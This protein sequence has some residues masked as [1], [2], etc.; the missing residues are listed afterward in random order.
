MLSRITQRSSNR[1]TKWARLFLV[2]AALLLCI[3]GVAKVVSALGTAPVLA[4]PDPIFGIR[5]DHLFMVVGVIELVIAVFCLIPASH[6]LA[7]GL[8]A[9]LSIDFL[10]YRAG[11]WLTRF[12][13]YCPCLGTLTQAIHLSPHRANLLTRIVLIYLMIGS[14][15]FL[16][17]FWRR[18]N[19]KPKFDPEFAC[20]QAPSG[21]L[22]FNG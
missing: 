13:G 10:G 6:K 20:N 9:V 1:V 2:S 18:R 17:D 5:F 15:Y 7:L 12:Q 11:L 21:S 14:F 16:V 8:V 3:T 19:L 4:K 22:S